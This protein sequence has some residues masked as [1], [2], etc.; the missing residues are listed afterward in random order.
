MGDLIALNDEYRALRR[1]RGLAY[2]SLSTIES[3]KQN[4]VGQ[5]DTTPEGHPFV[6]LQGKINAVEEEAKRQQ[7]KCDQIET[8]MT[9]IV[10]QLA[11][12]HKEDTFSAALAFFSKKLA[13]R[14]YFVDSPNRRDSE[15]LQDQSVFS[16]SNSNFSA[17]S[18]ESEKEHLIRKI[19]LV[20]GPDKKH[21]D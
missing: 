16:I 2:A 18:L 19:G 7:T 21:N 9:A 1:E 12:R 14:F 13:P 10:R 17:Q 8:R 4:L 3:K 11:E 15:L 5:L 6:V 20:P